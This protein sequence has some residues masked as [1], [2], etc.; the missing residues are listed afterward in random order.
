MAF[1]KWV[2]EHKETLIAIA[3]MLISEYKAGNP[4]TKYQGVVRTVIGKKEEG[5]K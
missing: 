5:L 2:I 3:T 4:N 1:V